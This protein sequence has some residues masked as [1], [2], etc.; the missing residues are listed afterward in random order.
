MSRQE[1]QSIRLLLT[2]L[3]AQPLHGVD[4]RH[5]QVWRPPEPGKLGPVVLSHRWRPLAAALALA[6]AIHVMILVVAPGIVVGAA[7][8]A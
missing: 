1:P 7:A 6:A 5:V 2:L 3:T 4:E 8:V